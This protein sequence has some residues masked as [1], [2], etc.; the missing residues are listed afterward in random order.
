VRPEVVVDV[1]ALGA[2]HDGRLR[3]PAYKGLRADLTPADL[4]ETEG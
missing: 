3:Q 2:T 4:F 1:T